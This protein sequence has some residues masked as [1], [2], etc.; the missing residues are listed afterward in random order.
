MLADRDPVAI[1]GL[2]STIGLIV[3]HEDEYREY[4]DDYYDEVQELLI[5][6]LASGLTADRTT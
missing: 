4:S 1:L 6:T 5:T 2:L 3:L